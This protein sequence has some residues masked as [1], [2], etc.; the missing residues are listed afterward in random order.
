MKPN[1]GYPETGCQGQFATQ[2]NR[3]GRFEPIQPGKRAATRSPGPA[4]CM[5]GRCA[6]DSVGTAVTGYRGY[7]AS[8]LDLGATRKRHGSGRGDL[9][10]RANQ[11]EKALSRGSRGLPSR[12]TCVAEWALR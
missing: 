4:G 9:V 7:A 6:G 3:T 5:P 2:W 1:S 10:R 11:D 12:D 8:I